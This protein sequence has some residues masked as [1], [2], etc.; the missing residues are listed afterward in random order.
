VKLWSAYKD[1]NVK[2]VPTGSRWTVLDKALIAK[3][4]FE[5]LLVKLASERELTERDQ[6][7][8]G[9]FREGYQTL[10]ESIEVDEKVP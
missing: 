4:G 6:R 8:L 7:M 9:C 5:A 2:D 1:S 3:N 10:R